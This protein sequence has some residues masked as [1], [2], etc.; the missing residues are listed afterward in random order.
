MHFSDELI[1]LIDAGARPD[2]TFKF[3]SF[4]HYRGASTWE[5]GLSMRETL[6]NEVATCHL[7]G[8]S[9]NQLKKP[10][11]VPVASKHV[12]WVCSAAQSLDR[13]RHSQ[14]GTQY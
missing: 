7:N 13:S 2:F 10:A 1:V 12:S 4:A 11:S 3:F 8:L 6:A 14:I 9:N 5:L